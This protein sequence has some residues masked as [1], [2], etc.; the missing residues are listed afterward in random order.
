[1][2]AHSV[3]PS[4]ITP[5]SIFQPA[6]MY[7]RRLVDQI[8]DELLL[9]GSGIRGADIL[10]DALEAADR[11][12]SSMLLMEHYS[13]FDLPCL[14]RFLERGDEDTR[15]V[16]DRII[17]IA[18]V[19]LNEESDFVRSFTEAYTRIVVY[20]SRSLAK[21]KD[22]HERAREEA[23]ARAINLPSL[24]RIVDEKNAGNLI[25]MYPSGT[26]FRADRPETR[27]GVREVGSYVK[28]FDR[29]IPIGIAGNV[30]RISPDEDM[31]RDLVVEDV[32]TIEVAE[33][34]SSKAY[35]DRFADA[36]IDE[37]EVKQAIADGVMDE[38]AG[39]HAKAEQRR[40]AALAAIAARAAQ[41]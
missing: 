6:N 28:R 10:R 30:L 8:L 26:R 22:P 27:H 20:P 41:S 2:I 15:P 18:G 17:A 32:V 25:L 14:I 16:A 38:L 4:Y 36:S 37:Q 1:M 35:R 7:N 9:P 3:Q 13:N 5:E 33:P 34:I 12:V 29:L 31:S 19:K 39:V 23:R 40:Q 24:Q 21:I 11:G